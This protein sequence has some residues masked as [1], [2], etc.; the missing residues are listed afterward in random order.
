MKRIILLIAFAL[1]PLVVGARSPRPVGAT[2]ARTFPY[3]MVGQLTFFSGDGSYVGSGTVVQPFG[4]LTAGHNLY[5]AVGGWSTDLVFKRGHYDDT[6]LTVRYAA[7]SY[8][9]AGYQSSVQLYGG[10]DARSFARDTGGL[11]FQLRPAAGGYLGW[12]TDRT[13]LTTSAPKAAF[14]YGADIHS[15]E[16]LLVVWATPFHAV[17]QTFYESDN[18]EI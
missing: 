1:L 7:R 15:G 4:V 10:D 18:T 14:G 11:S 5:D 6:D 13:I 2:V 3:S 8:V 12:T 9:L 17:Y 16:Q